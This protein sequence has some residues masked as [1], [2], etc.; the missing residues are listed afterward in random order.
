MNWGAALEEFVNKI[1]SFFK[2]R[3]LQ[4]GELNPGQLYDS[5]VTLPLGHQDFI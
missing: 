4:T 5:P 2:K 3:M 1:L